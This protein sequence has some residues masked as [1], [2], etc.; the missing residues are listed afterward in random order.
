MQTERKTIEAE[1]VVDRRRGRPRLTDSGSAVTTWLR[2]AEHDRLIKLANAE[3]TTV[4]ALVRSFLI[5][6]LNP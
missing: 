3:E 1:Y 4:S 5:L 6:R 2:A